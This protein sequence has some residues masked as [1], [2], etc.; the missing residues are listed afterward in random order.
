MCGIVGF[1]DKTKNRT[2]VGENILEMLNALGA[3]G[4]DSAGV[5]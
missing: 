5:A 2:S 3:R 4:L 1:L